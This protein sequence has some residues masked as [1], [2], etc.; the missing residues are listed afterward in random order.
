ME[1]EASLTMILPCGSP[2]D[3]ALLT[4]HDQ[5]LWKVLFDHRIF[6]RPLWRNGES[7][8]EHC[9]RLYLPLI[10]RTVLEIRRSELP[11]VSTE[12]LCQRLRTRLLQ[13]F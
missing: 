11:R 5:A 7:G 2:E 6:A 8:G 12:E 10:D 4:P 13:M 9:F 3:D 1:A